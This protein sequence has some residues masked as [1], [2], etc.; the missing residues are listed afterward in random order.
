MSVCGMVMVRRISNPRKEVER[1]GKQMEGEAGPRPAG[2][3]TDVVRDCI[4]QNNLAKIPSLFLV[5]P[6]TNDSLVMFYV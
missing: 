1:D 4:K 6:H 5:P 2:E 3:E